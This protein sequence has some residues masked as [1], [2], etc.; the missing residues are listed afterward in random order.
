MYKKKITLLTLASLM[1]LT[2]S[3]FAEE[4]TSEQATE[5]D[6][7]A[8]D[9]Y[10]PVGVAPS[11]ANEDALAAMEQRWRERDAR[12]QELVERAKEMGVMLPNEPPWSS[13]RNEMMSDMA[14]RRS[15]HQAMMSMTPE[16][17]MAA[18][19]AELQAMRERA[20]DRGVSRPDNPYGEA[21]QPAGDEDWARHQAVIDGMTDEQRAACHAMHRRHMGMARYHMPERP[22]YRGQG[23]GP[24]MMGPG[25]ME[26]GWGGG[27]MG[28]GYGY[29]P[30]PYGGQNFWDPNQ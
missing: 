11:S 2:S 30:N 15:R 14:A 16:E 23:M 9:Q 21:G 3:L 29:G 25:A 19:E 13:A 10:A 26:P 20:R 7:M 6:V 27:P 28:P 8:A 17:R 12:Y 18:R 5:A 1:T 22:M 4:A 24:G